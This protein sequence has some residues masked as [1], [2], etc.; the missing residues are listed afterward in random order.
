[1]MQRTYEEQARELLSLGT[2]GQDNCTMAEHS[3]SVLLQGIGFAVLALAAELRAVN[4][5]IVAR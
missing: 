4:D 2:I 3:R 1:M 5:R